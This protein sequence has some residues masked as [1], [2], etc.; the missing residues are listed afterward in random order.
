MEKLVNLKCLLMSG[1]DHLKMFPRNLLPNFPYLQ[2]L[3]LPHQILIPIEEVK[4]L[5][6][7]Q[8]YVGPIKDMHDLNLFI[9]SQQSKGYD[10]NYS[11][12]V[13]DCMGQPDTQSV[14]HNFNW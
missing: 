3:H 1:A 9:R 14:Y 6:Q 2:C 10:T 5:K 12:V 4:S 13:T 7:L 8:E 11:I